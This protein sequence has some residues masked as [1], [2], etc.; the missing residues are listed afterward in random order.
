MKIIIKLLG[1]FLLIAG[2]L[3]LIYPDLIYSWITK[4]SGTKLLYISATIG[5]FGLGML[6]LF[7]AGNSRFPLAIRIFGGLS[8]IASV[9][10]LLMGHEKFKLFLIDILPLYQSY[11][12]VSGLLSLAVGTFLIYA[13]SDLKNVKSIN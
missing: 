13:F 4:N 8:L 1:I 3:L 7:A 6:L 11:A 9:V 5:R 12:L 10:F 2:L